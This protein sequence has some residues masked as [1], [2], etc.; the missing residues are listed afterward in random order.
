MKKIQLTKTSREN[1]ATY[2]MVI[3]AYAVLQILGAAGLLSSTM[4]GQLVPIWAS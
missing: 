3:A 2:G 4:R 1:F